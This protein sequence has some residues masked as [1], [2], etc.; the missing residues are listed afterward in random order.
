MIASSSAVGVAV[1]ELASTS[2]SQFSLAKA[3]S[4]EGPLLIFLHGTC[5]LACFNRISDVYLYGI[6]STDPGTGSGVV[7]YAHSKGR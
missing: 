5:Q 4:V 3:K 1:R 7:W 2:R 6:P